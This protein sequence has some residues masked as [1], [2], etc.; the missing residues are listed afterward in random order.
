MKWVLLTIFTAILSSSCLSVKKTIRSADE[1]FET[2]A[3]RFQL[4]IDADTTALRSF[5]HPDLLYIHSNGLEETLQGHLNNIGGGKIDYQ[6]FTP[7]LPKSVFIERNSAFVDGL[8][9]VGG[10]YEGYPFTVNLR[11]TAVYKKAQDRWQLFRWQST[12]IEED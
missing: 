8:V 10:L 9:V 2:E 12:K 4:T 1:V 3:Q 5:L 11:Y 6:S 7:K